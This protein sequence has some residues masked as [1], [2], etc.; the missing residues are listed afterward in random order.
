MVI[1]PQQTKRPTV[2]HKKRHGQHQKQTKH[3]LKTYWPYIP[4]LIVADAINALISMFTV[5]SSLKDTASIATPTRLQFWMHTSYS[6]TLVVCGMAFA[7]MMYVF[8][9]H[10]KA[11]RR[12][13]ISGEHFIVEHHMID[14]GIIG[15]SLLG[16]IVTRSV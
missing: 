2:T 7:G 15:F 13:V 1:S 3:Y 9:R 16:I 14:V 8:L 6:T 4:L 10:A 5:H 11:W 12:V